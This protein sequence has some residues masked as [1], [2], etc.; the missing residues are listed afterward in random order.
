[1]SHQSYRVNS[2]WTQYVPLSGEDQGIEYG[3]H[4][5]RDFTRNEGNEERLSIEPSDYV[6]NAMTAKINSSWPSVIK[7]NYVN[8]G[9]PQRVE[10]NLDLESPMMET[11]VGENAE[12]VMTMEAS[13]STPFNLNWHTFEV[14]L[15]EMLSGAVAIMT[16][17]WVT[18]SYGLR[19]TAIVQGLLKP[20]LRGKWALKLKWAT[21]HTSAVSDKYDS[22]T[23]AAAVQLTGFRGVQTLYAI[24]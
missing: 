20:A 15:G 8:V 2:A 12:V 19:Y 4:A 16:G 9:D 6:P 17:R 21:Q 7:T 23:Y 22:I 14:D 1:M 3:T 13:A 24:T 18:S 11:L 5:H 10:L